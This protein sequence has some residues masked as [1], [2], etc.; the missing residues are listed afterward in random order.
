MTVGLVIV[1][2]SAQL[3]AGVAELAGQMVQGKTP[4]ATAGGGVDDILGTSADKILAA[5]Q[6]VDGPDGVL[7]LLDLGSALLSAEV[8]LE[9]LDDEQREHTRLSFAPLVEGAV[10]AA[11][12]A[13]VGHILVQV[14]QAAE[15]TASREQL[16]ML[17]PV[18]QEEESS[19]P[20]GAEG[21]EMPSAERSPST[22]QLQEVYET[23]LVLTNHAGLHARPAGLFVQTA[24]RFQAKIQVQ[25]GGR[26]T[27][28]ASI[29]GVLSL[30]ARQGET[31]TLRASGSDAEDAIHALSELVQANFYETPSVEP[32]QEPAFRAGAPASDREQATAQNPAI[33][34]EAVEV[35]SG[36]PQMT[37]GFW[38]GITTSAGVALGPALLYTSASIALSKVERHTIS[39]EQISS[40]QARLR[41]AL[42]DAAQ[43]L[44]MLATSLQSSVGKDQAAI[45][46]AQALMLQDPALLEVALK[47]IAEQQLDAVSAL[48]AT[49]EQHASVLASIDDPLFAARATDMRDAVSRALQHLSPD[50]VTKQD[51]TTLSK[52]VILVARELSPSDT[53]HLQPSLVLGICT[54]QGGPTA[55][56]S[57]LARALG[58][59]AIAGLNEAVLQA[60]HSGDELGLDADNGVLYST[61]TPEVHSELS[62]RIKERQQQQTALKTAAQETHA[63]VMVNGQRISLLANIGSEAEAEAARQWGAEGIGLLRTEFLFASASTLPDE[64]EQYQRY[65]RVFRAFIGDRSTDQVGPIVVRTLDAGADKPMAALD[66]VLGPMKEA[67][68]ALGLRGIRIHLAHET[69]LEQ[70]LNAL[71]RAAVETGIELHIMFPMIS[72]VEELRT[73]REIFDRVYLGLDSSQVNLPTHVSIGIMVEVPAAVMMARELA[74]LADFFSI[75][76]N[77]LLQYTLAADRT[78]ANVVNLYSPMQPAL[79]RFIRQIAEAGRE[80][81]KVVAVCGEMASDARLA[82]VLVGLGVTELSMTPTALPAVRAALSRWSSEDLGALAE[83]VSQLKTV[84]EVEEVLSQG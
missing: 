49:G 53:A 42:S 12:E 16:Q 25:K 79:L 65:V 56:A 57:I 4:I 41:N 46:D 22:D 26:Q 32:V 51:L 35:T 30:G 72:T 8:A 54:T 66:G 11:V 64:E 81:G 61:L 38:Q 62:R 74:E 71:L 5:I 80:A 75:G 3:A 55:H 27:D 19:V 33:P 7:V 52:P 15:K 84:A 31:I 18:S 78:N 50:I 29:S 83:K 20:V 6:S 76:A 24:A 47:S 1:S 77:D 68:P 82:P 2:H 23:Q 63:P 28:A 73:A 43:E 44:H 10:A 34:T 14:Q 40:E 45:F 17:K 21:I 48:A 69:L 39:L 67:N 9:M 37:G 59:P 13:S 58:I 36:M 70:Q 60:I